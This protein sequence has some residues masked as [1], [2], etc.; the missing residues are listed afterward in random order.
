MDDKSLLN[1]EDD[2]LAL[3][4]A[5]RRE[6]RRRREQERRRRRLRRAIPWAAMA[7]AAVVLIP[8]GVRQARGK[9]AAV[10]SSAAAS[11]AVSSAPA[12]SAEP[13]APFSAAETSATIQLGEEIDS[14]YAV[15]I[16][17]TS[18]EI[19]AEKNAKTIVNPASMTKV[20]TV[21][22]AAEHVTNLDDSFTIPVEITD[23]CFSHGCSAVGFAVGERVTVRDLFYGTVLPSGA[24]AALGLATYVA[25][26]QEAFVKLMNEKAAQLGLSDGANFTNCIGL[27][28]EN[29]HCSVYDMALILNAAADNPICREVLSAHTYTTSRTE[30]HPEGIPLSNWFLRRIEDKDAGGLTV[31]CAKTGYVVQAGSCAASYAEGSGTELIC[32]TAKAGSAWRC[33]YDHAALYK[34]T[35]GGAAGSQ[36]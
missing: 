32:V 12:E 34:L 23:Y 17:R 9:T 3:R 35:A 19:L 18:G 24:D 25:G 14:D 5:R 6:E 26:S 33:I 8:L 7:I 11:P 36:P 29:H 27:Y 1:Q 22:V 20:L 4:R 2:E 16:D 28:D 21:L 13:Q 15:V 30:A 10:S 31:R